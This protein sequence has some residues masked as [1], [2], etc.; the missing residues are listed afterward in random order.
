M[1]AC[2]LCLRIFFF[3]EGDEAKLASGPAAEATVHRP[4]FP[5]R[6]AAVS[7]SA[8]EGLNNAPFEAV[9]LN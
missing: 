6:P 8:K 5:L 3:R 4:S 2:A 1:V 9:L 7:H